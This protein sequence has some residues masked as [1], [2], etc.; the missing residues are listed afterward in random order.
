MAFAANDLVNFIGVP[1]AS[2]HA[3]LTAMAGTQPLTMPM[4]ALQKPVQTNTFFLLAAG[5][6]MVATLWL[7]RKAHTVTKTEVNLGRQEEGLERFDSSPDFTH[8]CSYGAQG[9]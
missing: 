3:Y 8:Y 6:V 9:V 4:E 7:S 5:A 1:L 2:F